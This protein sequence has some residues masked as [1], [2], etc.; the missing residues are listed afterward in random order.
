MKI[1][2]HLATD[3]IICIS[4]FLVIYLFLFIFIYNYDNFCYQQFRIF[5][6]FSLQHVTCIN[7]CGLGSLLYEI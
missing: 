6:S 4:P 3:R 2:H 5:E 7:P 1:K